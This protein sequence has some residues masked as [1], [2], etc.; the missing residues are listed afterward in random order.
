MGFVVTNIHVR[1]CCESCSLSPGRGFCDLGTVTVLRPSIQAANSRFFVFVPYNAILTS[2]PS[3][4]RR[5]ERRLRGGEAGAP[6]LFW[7]REV[8]F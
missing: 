3:V 8:E 7:W 4:G 2:D 6:V 1:N 5:T